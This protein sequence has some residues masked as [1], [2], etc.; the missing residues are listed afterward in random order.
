MV[1][2]GGMTRTLQM[3]VGYAKALELMMTSDNIDAAEALRIG[4]VSKVVPQEQLMD[5]ARNLAHRLLKIAP[6]SLSF[7]KQ[8]AQHGWSSDFVGQIEF[9]SWGQAIC[10]N[11]EDREEGIRSFLEKRPPT[12][13]S[14]NCLAV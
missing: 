3:V 2:D 11:S 12:N 6:L 10:R 5:E 1:P 7:I 8:A 4:L 9:E 13:I 14:C